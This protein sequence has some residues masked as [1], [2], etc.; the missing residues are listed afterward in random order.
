MWDDFPPERQ[1][2]E[3]TIQQQRVPKFFV[4]PLVLLGIGWNYI[5]LL[6]II[7]GVCFKHV[8]KIDLCITPFLINLDRANTVQLSVKVPW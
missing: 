6:M 2:P 4:F 5:L 8:T 3:I 7:N 1:V